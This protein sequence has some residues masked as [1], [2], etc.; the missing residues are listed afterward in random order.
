MAGCSGGFPFRKSRLALPFCSHSL[1]LRS[2]RLFSF[3]DALEPRLVLELEFW[4]LK[5]SSEPYR[6]VVQP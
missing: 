4:I 1:D 5:A 2:T 6:L 3:V